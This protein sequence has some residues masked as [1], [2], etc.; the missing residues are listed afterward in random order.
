MQVKFRRYSGG[1]GYDGSQYSH[2][3]MSKHASSIY[4]WYFFH[5][6]IRTES[7]LDQDL[8]SGNNAFEEFFCQ[9]PCLGCYPS[10][11]FVRVQVDLAT[12][13]PE[14]KLVPVRRVPR[15]KHRSDL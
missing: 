10:P 11:V 2:W 14:S 7:A 9:G 4:S 3:Q 15:D 13:N 12:P 1:K 6:H 5:Y 8:L